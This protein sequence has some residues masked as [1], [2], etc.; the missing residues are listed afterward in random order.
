MREIKFRGLT[1]DNKWVYGSYVY[2]QGRFEPKPTIIHVS[3]DLELEDKKYLVDYQTV[4]QFT[5]LTDKTGA[6][7][8]EGDVMQYEFEDDPN[9]TFKI[10]WWGFG[11]SFIYEGWECPAKLTHFQVGNAKVIGNIHQNP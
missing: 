8:Y 7:I 3:D 5:G 9:N 10:V 6:P 4:G 11:W 1:D 2:F